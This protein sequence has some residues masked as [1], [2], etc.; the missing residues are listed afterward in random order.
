[1]SSLARTGRQPKSTASQLA[2]VDLGLPD[3]AEAEAV[4]LDLAKVFAD[5]ALNAL[6]PVLNQL[7]ENRPAQASDVRAPNPE[8]K[9]RALL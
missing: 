1:M 6:P 2:D 8:A 9:Y 4:L 3:I 5:P 7:S